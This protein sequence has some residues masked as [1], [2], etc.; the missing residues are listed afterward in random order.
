MKKLKIFLND[1][2]RKKFNNI[3]K[4]IISVVLA[5]TVVISIFGLSNIFSSAEG[6]IPNY[7]LLKYFEDGSAPSSESPWKFGIKDYGVKPFFAEITDG[8]KAPIAVWDANDSKA[9]I[10]WDAYTDA[11]GYTLNIYEG[12]TLLH[13]EDLTATTWS[14]GADGKI[15]GG[16][17]YD[18]QVLALDS[19]NKV[20]AATAICTFN[21]IQAAGNTTSIIQNFSDATVVDSITLAKHYPR[22]SINSD[23]QLV[24]GTTA[25]GTWGAATIPGDIRC[26]NAK[27]VTF[28]VKAQEGLAYQFKIGFDTDYAGS[29]KSADAYVVSAANPNNYI[30]STVTSTTS[31]KG[32]NVAFTDKTYAEYTDGYYVIIPLSIYADAT[33]GKIASGGYSNFY[34]S[35]REPFAKDGSG[36]YTTSVFDGSDIIVDDIAFIS[37]IDLFIEDLQKANNPGGGSSDEDDES[38]STVNKNE[39]IGVVYADKFENNK[40]TNEVAGTGYNFY[41]ENSSRQVTFNA[42]SEGSKDIGAQLRF[43]APEKGLYD[44]SGALRVKDNGGATDATVK[45]RVIKIDSKGQETVVWANNSGNWA[46][47]D[48]TSENLT[49]AFAFPAAQVSLNKDE[50]LAIETYVHSNDGTAANVELS[51]GNPTTTV[52]EGTVTYKGSSV[53]YPFGNYAIAAISD[54]TWEYKQQTSR[55]ESVMLHN[56]NGIVTHSEFG[57]FKVD[58]ANYVFN[59][60]PT[61][62]IGYYYTPKTTA[63][64]M[65][66]DLGRGNYG[67]ALKFSAPTSGNATILVPMRGY[68]GGTIKYRVTKNGAT[69]HPADAAW[70]PVSNNDIDLAVDCGVKANDVIAIEFYSTS[71]AKEEF[72]LSDAPSVAISDGSS[73]NALGDKTFSPL[74]ER[75]Y[76]GNNYSGEIAVPVGA[77]WNFGLYNVS[78]KTVEAVDFYNS[79]KKMLY[80]DG[81]ADVGYVFEDEQLKF[82]SNDSYGLSLSYAALTSGYYDFSTA[83]NI[84][85]GSGTLYARVMVGGKKVWPESEDWFTAENANGTFDAIEVGVEAGQEIVL[86]AYTKLTAGEQNTSGQPA[87]PMVIGLGAPVVQCLENRVFTETGNTTDY[88]PADYTAFED[89]YNGEYIKLNSRFMYSINGSDISSIDA[90]NKKLS[91]DSDNYFK[92]TDDVLTVNL[93]AGSNAKI[94]FTSPMVGNGTL[95]LAKSL[96]SGNAEFKLLK[97]TNTLFD[98]TSTLPETTEIS[99]QKNDVFTLEIRTENGAEVKFDTFSVLMLG[100]HNNAN[101]ATDDGFYAIHANPYGD[102]LYEGKYKKTDASFWNFDFYNVEDDEIVNSNYYNSKNK[103]LSYSKVEDLAYYF[104]TKELT[105]DINFAEK[106]GLALGFTAPRRDVFNARMGLRLTT[107]GATA[108]VAVRINIISAS[109]GKTNQIWPADGSWYEQELKTNNDIAIPYVEYD[110]EKGDTVYVEIYAKDSDVNVLNFNLVSPAFF[111][112]NTM[113]FSHVDVSAKLYPAASYSPGGRI[114]NYSGVHIPMQNRWNFQVAEVEVEN[115]EISF[116]LFDFDSVNSGVK[117]DILYYSP[118]GNS[119]RYVF[120]SKSFTVASCLTPEKNFGAVY[121]FIAPSTNTFNINAPISISAVPIENAAL[122][123]S[124]VKVSAIDGTET[125]VWPND[126]ENEWEVLDNTKLGSECTDIN[127]DANVGDKFVFRTYWD[128]DEDSLNQYFA[129]KTDKKWFPV[130]TATPTITMIES[131]N[132]TRTNFSSSAQFINEYLIS[133]FWR[134]EYSMDSDNI[135]WKPA[136]LYSSNHWRPA[137]DTNMGISN[138]GRYMINNP[139]GVRGDMKPAL[140][141]KFTPLKSGNIILTNKEASIYEKSSSEGCDVEIRITH[142]G[143]NIYPEQGWLRLTMGDKAEFNNIDFEVSEGDEV[144]FEMRLVEPLPTDNIV[145]LSWEPTFSM[146]GYKNIYTSTTDIYNLLDADTYAMFKEMGNNGEFDQDLA[147]NKILSEKIKVE[148]ENLGKFDSETD[149]EQQIQDIP[150]DEII[151]DSGDEYFEED[152]DESVTDEYTEWTEEVVT[153]GGKW[154]K[155]IRRYVTAWWVYALIIAGAVLIVAAVVVTLIILRKKGKIGKS[156]HK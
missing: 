90:K 26:D 129:E 32:F 98:W 69:I 60:A 13:T 24:I 120:L 107:A 122:K 80:K 35:I 116:N 105:A 96:V 56:D 85:Q 102:Q 43:V 18:I 94:V 67:V 92:F 150:S 66:F 100:K 142:N 31:S 16:K 2:D 81:I 121:D 110:L 72:T 15:E 79:S 23:G 42:T 108:K 139:G 104:G 71:S 62:K 137:E 28:F 65:K 119:H 53:T 41:D 34:L 9:N 144:R 48:I 19:S 148:M 86:Q 134:V 143:A 156:R 93:A 114:G 101:A 149:D 151:D 117:Q 88:I 146:G 97:G 36:Q 103:S 125:I 37:D 22:K 84:L 112:E 127:V 38:T 78:S 39:V 45:Y 73:A 136:T 10:S 57:A 8:Y 30:S 61:G 115:E 11:T 126:G 51:F 89:G 118:N 12:T 7:P 44:L 75:P 153:P 135:V 152:F 14:S 64:Q 128:V 140:A 138:K 4:R 145:Y 21:V 33:F 130:Y 82:I 147:A 76:N 95:A 68:S 52:V 106:H 17:T 5:A 20:I 133:P 111:K 1:L 74:W 54:G 58:N 63:S 50:V 55:W 113:Q 155:V 70:A 124:I 91:V 27:A 87:D 46:T 25:N 77:V 3:S 40:L 141:L 47:G 132:D 123:Y 59:N 154:R 6:T 83:L 29:G 109:D 99:A 49:P 131:I